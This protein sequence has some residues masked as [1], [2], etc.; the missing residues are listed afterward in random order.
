MDRRNP[1]DYLPDS[2]KDNDVYREAEKDDQA[3]LNGI[4]GEV[5]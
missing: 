5:N 3:V 4:D 2:W 1:F